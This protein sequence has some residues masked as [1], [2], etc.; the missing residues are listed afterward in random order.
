M[1]HARVATLLF[2][3]ILFLIKG[4]CAPF[5]MSFCQY[6]NLAPPY[7]YLFKYDIIIGD[8]PYCSSPY[9]KFKPLNMRRIIVGKHGIR[10]LKLL[11]RPEPSTRLTTITYQ[12]WLE[13]ADLHCRRLIRA[14]SSTNLMPSC[15]HLIRVSVLLWYLPKNLLFYLHSL[16]CLFHDTNI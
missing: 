4:L 2:I 8:K 10:P 6:A 9:N 5:F 15:L 7:V 16:L 11:Y 3:L 13:E 12:L 14:T 1:I